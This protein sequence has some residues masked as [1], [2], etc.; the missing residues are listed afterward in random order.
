LEGW[1]H[2]AP[3]G[4]VDFTRRNHLPEVSDLSTDLWLW[5]PGP[6]LAARVKPK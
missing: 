3:G 1:R 4:I 5:R 6:M 2:T